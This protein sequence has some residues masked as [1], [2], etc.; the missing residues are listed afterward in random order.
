MAFWEFT[1]FTLFGRYTIANETPASIILKIKAAG[2]RVIFTCFINYKMSYP[3]SAKITLLPTV[4]RRVSLEID[5]PSGA[6]GQIF[7]TV[8]HLRVC[9][10]GAL[11]LTKDGSAVYNYCWFTP[12]QSFSG[13]SPMGH[14]TIFYCPSFETPPNWRTRTPYLYPPGTGWLG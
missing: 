5:R 2:S 11:S 9:W 3:K 1:P 13:L 14:V 6:Y 7:I 12:G 8:R 10:C 4:S